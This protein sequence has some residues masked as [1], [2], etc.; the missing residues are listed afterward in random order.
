MS[1]QEKI[2]GIISKYWEK[3]FTSPLTMTQALTEALEWQRKVIILEQQKV[4][5]PNMVIP[6]VE[7]LEQF[8]ME[9]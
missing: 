1:E 8:E 9:D 5:H 3:D 6:T 7:Q 4:K 2:E